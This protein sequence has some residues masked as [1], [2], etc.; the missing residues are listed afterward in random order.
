MSYVSD[1]TAETLYSFLSELLQDREVFMYHDR[2]FTFWIIPVAVKS[3][4][5]NVGQE[6]NEYNCLGNTCAE[7]NLI[8]GVAH[9]Y[10]KRVA[11]IDLIHPNSA[12]KIKSLLTKHGE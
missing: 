5:H 3:C 7:I 6:H 11:K 10:W 1:F 4:D 2:Y 12:D 9:I 8:E